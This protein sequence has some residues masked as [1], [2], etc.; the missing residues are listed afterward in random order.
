MTCHFSRSLLFGGVLIFAG[1][2]PAGISAAPTVVSCSPTKVKAALSILDSSTT[3][4]SF[5]NMPEA[6]VNFVQ[7]GKKPSCVIVRFSAE[8]AAAQN[9]AMFV[10]AVLDNATVAI[11]SPQQFTVNQGPIFAF[12][13]HSYDFVFPSVTPGTHIV[14][15]QYGSSNGE[16][17]RMQNRATIV[18]FA[19]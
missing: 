5:V 16:D 19:P 14:R 10:R 9:T 4:Q 8:V 7:G 12:A 1:L 3:V 18:H 2:A 11:P 15:M 13:A 17:V 6:A